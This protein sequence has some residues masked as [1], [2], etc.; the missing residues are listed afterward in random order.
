MLYL[1]NQIIVLIRIMITKMLSCWRN[2]FFNLLDLDLQEQ[3]AN[4][5][6]LDFDA[7]EVL[8]A[9][10]G[11]SLTTLWHDLIRTW[12]WQKGPILQGEELHSKG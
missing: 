3:I 4:G 10:L 9:L 5:K 2:L 1:D 12:W 8:E 7:A 6:E 11:N